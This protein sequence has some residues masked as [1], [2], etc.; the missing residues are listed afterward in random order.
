[1]KQNNNAEDEVTCVNLRMRKSNVR[2][3][4]KLAEASDRKTSSFI[5]WC[6]LKYLKTLEE[7]NINFEEELI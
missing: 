3:F 2:R 1:M 6:A 7:N 4:R 5:R